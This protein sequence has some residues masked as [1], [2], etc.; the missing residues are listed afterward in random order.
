[1]K[2]IFTREEFEKFRIEQA[3]KMSKNLELKERAVD[4]LQKSDHNYWIHQQNW[5]D[6]PIL[7]TPQDI[8]LLQEIIYKN[9]PRFIIE[10]G[11]CWGGLTLFLVSCVELFQLD[12]LVLGVDIFVPPDLKERIYDKAEHF[13]LNSLGLYNYHSINNHK[14]II[15]LIYT[16]LYPDSPMIS[17][18][19][20]ILDSA[21]DR[22]T[23]TKEL[24]LYHKYADNI[25]VCDTIL[26]EFTEQPLRKREWDTKENNPTTALNDFLFE[27]PEFKI[28][29]QLQNKLLLSCNTYLKRK[30]KNEQIYV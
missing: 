7:Q 5:M 9:K 18:G 27:H 10:L 26:S 14:E 3:Q 28:D 8:L 25:V 12:S 20:I 30:F 2:K 15:N 13:S 1:M 24:E 22:N 16:D 4:L 19:L 17:R 6:E 11:V 29:R 23:V 21:H